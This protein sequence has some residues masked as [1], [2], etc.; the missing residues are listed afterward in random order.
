MLFAS[1][2]LELFW[3]N[4]VCAMMYMALNSRRSASRCASLGEEPIQ[5]VFFGVYKYFILTMFLSLRLY[6]SRWPSLLT[7]FSSGQLAKFRVFSGQTWEF[8]NQSMIY[9][10]IPAWDLIDRR[11]VR[12]KD[13]Q[14]WALASGHA[15]LTETPLN[16]LSRSWAGCHLSLRARKPT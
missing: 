12:W 9:Y 11:I 6:F 5:Q 13:S 16:N 7:T 15:K 8:F 3:I 14:G 2:Q 1:C 4:S 10:W